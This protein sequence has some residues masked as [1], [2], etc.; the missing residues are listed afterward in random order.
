MLQYGA[1]T[2]LRNHRGGSPLHIA[3]CQ[4][5]VAIAAA[6]LDAGADKEARMV[7]GRSPLHLA[8]INGN[9]DVVML[10]LRNQAF[11][12]HCDRSR[13]QTPLSEAAEYGLAPTIRILLEAGADVE[14]TSSEGLTPLHWACCYNHSTSVEVLLASGANPDVVDGAAAKAAKSIWT[15]LS[16]TS[17]FVNAFE[18]TA[19][20]VVGLG[21]PSRWNEDAR[22]PFSGELESEAKQRLNLVSRSKT[23]C[24]LQRARKNRAWR[25]RGWLLVLANRQKDVGNAEDMSKLT[26]KGRM[27]ESKFTDSS[28][29]GNYYIAV[30]NSK[31]YDSEPRVSQ[32]WSVDDIL[33]SKCRDATNYSQRV[34]SLRTTDMNGANHASDHPGMQRAPKRQHQL[35]LGNVKAGDNSS[36]LVLTRGTIEA[37]VGLASVELA[38]FRNVL[39][40]I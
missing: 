11:T 35:K 34:V 5:S 20:D 37:L 14:S 15:E 18:L 10:L 3:A 2:D 23:I 36:P 4:G 27:Q 40:F 12:E 9:V 16:E 31:S 29:T 7:N 32:D 21:D 6:L 33:C 26:S 24:A 25:R 17:P 19:S 22:R 13:G 28:T 1:E 38:V 8:V 39:R 30:P